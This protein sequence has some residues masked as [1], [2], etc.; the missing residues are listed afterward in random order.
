MTLTD[1]LLL[2][3]QNL[4]LIVIVML[5]LWLVS[6]RLKDVS[7]VDGVWPLGMLML[8]LATL[9][10]TAG[11]PTRKTV[12]VM[13]CA[14]WALRLGLHLLK[15]WRAHGADGRYTAIVEDQEKKK[16]WP[17]GKTALLF[18]FLPQAFLGWLTCLPVQ[19][20]QVA[21]APSV[22][23]IGLLG[24]ALAVFGVVF[25]STGDAQLA[26]FKRDPANKGK[27]LDIG[28]WRYTRHPNYFG[29]ACVWW[30][31]W[32][33]AAE[34][35]PGLWSI[36]GPIFLT[37]TLTRWSGIGITEKATHQSRPGYADYVKR[38][39]AFFPAPPRKRG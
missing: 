34:T 23:L 20:G 37:F 27:V 22:G 3:G 7:F 35:G 4:A 30:G 15:R 5:A 1:I 2:L 39:S 10:R 31:L 38:T 25:E 17:F 33:I 16:G 18:V 21:Q 19:L 11:D 14:V 29:D 24:A 9:P 32:L 6:L 13:I 8:A 28:L 36:A 12:L 26:A